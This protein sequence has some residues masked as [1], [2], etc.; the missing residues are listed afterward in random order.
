MELSRVI[1]DHLR[2]TSYVE[3]PSQT[4]NVTKQSLLDAVGVMIAASTLGEA[5]TPFVEI[6]A[7][8]G[9]IHGAT[10]LGYNYRVAPAMAAFAN[11]SM[12]HSL[13][14]EDTFDAAMVHPNAAV[15][16]AALAIAETTVGITGRD[17]LTAIALGSD[18]SCRLALAAEGQ[19]DRDGRA[20]CSV[21][22]ATA[23]AGKLLGLDEEQ[24]VHAFALAMF[25]GSFRSEAM[26][27]ANSH[28]RAVREAF[29]AKAAVIAVQLAA[30]GVRAFDTPFE[31]KY[32]QMRVL[33]DLGKRFEGT[34]VSFKPWP[35]CRG[36]HSYIEAALALT[37]QHGV[38]PTQIKSVHTV[39]S[40]F[41]SSLFTPPAQKQRP[42]TA[43]DAKFSIPFTLAT[44]LLDHDVNLD[45]FSR[46]KMLDP[47][48]HR[49]AELIDFEVD[50]TF[51]PEDS[52]HGVLTL[53]LTDGR[54]LTKSVVHPLG[55]PSNP[56]SGAEMRQ[57]FQAC[58]AHSRVPI[59]A[60]VAEQLSDTI[61][62]IDEDEEVATLFKCLE[63]Q[64]VG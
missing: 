10:V 48:V 30:D 22:G 62:R 37:E 41:F 26:R 3:L 64:L 2:S 54:S 24:F 9:D 7:R 61:L 14:Y 16:P 21:F 12:A 18:L 31:H 34:A 63:V 4:A 53:N 1:V 45:S 58:A 19:P 60:G 36:T 5:C 13:D 6:A 38:E 32:D 28:M 47:E 55:H 15:V 33:D 17:L 23:A 52:S 42:A 51:G 20:F 44:A 8:V 57:K 50:E 46:M 25:Q 39:V 11:G 40:P 43:I 29:A 59:A 27:Y 49:M 35:S 56:M